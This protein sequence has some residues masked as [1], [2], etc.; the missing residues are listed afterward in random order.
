MMLIRKILEFD[1]D[2]AKSNGAI[3]KRTW[4]KVRTLIETQLSKISASVWD[5]MSK[6]DMAQSISKII[7]MLTLVS[8]DTEFEDLVK[9]YLRSEHR[10]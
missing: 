7:Y 9:E 8:H 2:T 5:G 4:G 10:K 3:N 6:H 1:I